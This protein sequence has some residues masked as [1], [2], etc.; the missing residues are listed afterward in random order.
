ML[1]IEFRAS[2]LAVVAVFCS[3]PNLFNY[4]NPYLTDAVG[5]LVLFLLSMCFLSDRLGVFAALLALGVFIR[6]SAFF[7]LPAWLLTPKRWKA[8][9]VGM[10][11]GGVFLALR[12]A[13]PSSFG[14]A[15][16]LLSG[17]AGKL[18]LHWLGNL[19]RTWS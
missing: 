14:Y 9:L 5:M 18:S 7:V 8:V 13:F 4:Y 6:E 1:G 15:S 19:P 17:V 16:Y 2:V 10:A 3:R 12:M 11:A